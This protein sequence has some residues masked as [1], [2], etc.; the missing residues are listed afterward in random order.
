MRIAAYSI[1]D[2]LDFVNIEYIAP[3]DASHL[4]MPE[5]LIDFHTSYTVFEHIPPENIIAILKEGRRILKKN[6]IFVHCIDYSD[7][8]SHSDKSISSINFLQFS[9]DQWH[10]IAGNRYAYTNQLRHDDF[11]NLF[12]DSSSN[13]LVDETNFD[14]SLLLKITQL[15]LSENFKF[16]P[17]EILAITSAWI[18]SE[19]MVV[20]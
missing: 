11:L 16:K 7:H 19:K 1:D 15:N 10:R 3:G 20:N 2:L 4:D 9:N 14:D 12:L 18:V 17:R 13:V 8:F 6:G 5:N